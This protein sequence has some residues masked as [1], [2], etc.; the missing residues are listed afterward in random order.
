MDRYNSP[1]HPSA[2]LTRMT[3]EADEPGAA[4][5]TA[6]GVAAM[7][8]ALDHVHLGWAYVGWLARLPGVRAVLQLLVDAIGGGPRVARAGG[9]PAGP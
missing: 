3:Y 6:R 1:A 5:F 4:T 9:P 7:A 8:Y 2:N